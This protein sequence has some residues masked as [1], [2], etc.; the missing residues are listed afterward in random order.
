MNQ[1]EFEHLLSDCLE[2]LARGETVEDCLARYPQSAQELAPLL[3]VAQATLATAA[4]LRPRPEAR[5]AIQERLSRAWR[6]RERK[7]RRALPLLGLLRPVLVALSLVLLLGF[8]GWGTAAASAGSLPGEPLYPVKKAGER[9]LLVITFSSEGKARRHVSLAN[10]RAKEMEVL[11][12]QQKGDQDIEGLAQRVEHH[13][14]A[15][16]FLVAGEKT[17]T[18]ATPATPEVPPAAPAPAQ[19]QAPGPQPPPR[20]ETTVAQGVASPSAATPT[21][22]PGV[23]SQEGASGASPP[24]PGLARRERTRLEIQ[25]LLRE[26]A[27]LHHTRM[28][29]ALGETPPPLRPGLRKALERSHQAFLEAVRELAEVEQKERE[30]LQEQLKEQDRPSQ[31]KEGPQPRDRGPKE[32]PKRSSPGR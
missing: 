12:H 18:L 31:H 32:Q 6:E 4:S 27:R 1:T 22:S 19:R 3:R 10:E 20:P 2:R 23:A 9:F 11:V 29:Q 26:R 25:Q 14:R 30:G 8:A 7:R 28:E 17:F 21:A 13:T 15:A 24:P 5:T 16:V